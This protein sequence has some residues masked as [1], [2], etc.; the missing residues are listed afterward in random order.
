M[1]TFSERVSYIVDKVGSTGRAVACIT[2]HP[3][4]Q[5]FGIT[6]EGDKPDGAP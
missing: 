6:R 3:C 4:W 2:I 1:D 5:H